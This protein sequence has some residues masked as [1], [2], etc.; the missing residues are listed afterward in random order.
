MS[1]MWELRNRSR[2][3]HRIFNENTEEDIASLL[4]LPNMDAHKIWALTAHSKEAMIREVISL[5]QQQTR[6]LANSLYTSENV[7]P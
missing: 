2:H 7:L 4:A 1:A 5:Q 3:H 6:T